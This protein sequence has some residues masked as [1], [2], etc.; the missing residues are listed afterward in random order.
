MGIQINLKKEKFQE[1]VAKTGLSF[2]KIEREI[3]R[4]YDVEISAMTLRIYCG[5]TKHKTYSPHI[6][7]LAILATYF[8]ETLNTKVEI[9]D[10]F[11][12]E[13]TPHKRYE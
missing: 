10:F 5:R 11:E 1:L 4:R 13:F 2:S 12:L 3:L 6:E 8:S 7:K 9:N